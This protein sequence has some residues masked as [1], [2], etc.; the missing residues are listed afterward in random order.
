M[1]PLLSFFMKGLFFTA[2]AEFLQLQPGGSV[3]FVFFGIKIALLTLGTLE[4]NWRSC[5]F[6]CHVLL[7]FIC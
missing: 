5:G 4:G 2:F 1:Q 3:G 7:Y 6:L